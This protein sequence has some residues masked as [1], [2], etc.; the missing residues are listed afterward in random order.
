MEHAAD[1]R[2][3]DERVGD[4][5]EAL[6]VE[7]VRQRLALRH[8]GAHLVRAGLEL[9][10]DAVG[11]DRVLVAVPGH[12]F[13]ADGGDVAAEAAEALDE[14][15]VDAGAGGGERGR[16]TRRPGAHDEHV[17]L[18]DHVD[19]AGGLGDGAEQAAGG[20]SVTA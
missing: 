9:A 1:A 19:L 2:L 15:H 6:G 17:G 10:P 18:V 11:L 4:D 5:L 14:R 13:D 20:T 12:A 8:G 3:L 7:L 16:E